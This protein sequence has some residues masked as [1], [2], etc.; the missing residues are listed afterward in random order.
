MNEA[1]ADN[2]TKRQMAKSSFLSGILFKFQSSILFRA[3][4][5]IA[6]DSP[7]RSEDYERKARRLRNAR[8]QLVKYNGN[9]IR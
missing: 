7:Q 6:A 3:A 5:A 1:F 2:A 9:S 8:I 4:L